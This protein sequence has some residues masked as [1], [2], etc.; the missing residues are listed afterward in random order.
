MP[1]LPSRRAALFLLLATFV[2]QAAPKAIP[3]KMD[4]LLLEG[5]RAVYNLHFDRAESLFEEAQLRYPEYPHG[6]VY[7]AYVNGMAFALDESND[8]LSTLV[9]QRIAIAIEKSEAYREAFP[10]DPDGYFYV[11]IASG[12]EAVVH[13]VERRFLKAYWSGRRAKKHLE[14]VIEIDSTY[15]DAYLGLGM[16]HYYADLLPGVLKFV[17]GLLGFDGDRDRG[18]DE[19]LRAAAN[20]HYFRVEGEFIFHSI[21]Y[22]LEGTTGPSLEGIKRLYGRFPDNVGLALM[23]GYH[24]RRSGQPERCIDYLGRVDLGDRN[25]PPQMFNLKHYHMGVSYYLLNDFARADSMFTAFEALPTRKSTYFTAAVQYYRGHLADLAF[26][27]ERARIHLERI[28]KSDKTD[29]WYAISRM[30]A[31]YPMDSL[32]YR[33]HIARNQLNSRRLEPALAGARSLVSDVYGG[34]RS[35]YP[36]ID[37]LAYDLLG[38]VYYAMGRIDES[39]RAYETI[40]H[41]VAEMDDDFHQ[42]WFYI[43]YA[44]C[45]RRMERY[46]EG[47][48][49]LNR[50]A[51]LDVAYVKIIVERERYI[52]RK[53][54]SAEAETE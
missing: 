20:G 17:A 51:E 44:R 33:Y 45:L 42:G 5:K 34:R 11:A 43:H 24:Y 52:I 30:A 27:R 41:R 15:A 39:R 25:L 48:E 23:L 49:M 4:R 2:L 29:Y 12:V 9:E 16:F 46:D 32:V 19:I 8:S 47:L 28:E 18:K 38:R 37:V 6:F 1:P 40:L 54:I 35:T 36:E 31:Q 22:F 10:D 14:T 7:Q 26:D 13:I 21:G 3:E 50:A 53:R